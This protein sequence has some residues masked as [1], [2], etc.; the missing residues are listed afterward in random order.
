MKCANTLHHHIDLATDTILFTISSG[1]ADTIIGDMFFNDDYQQ[2][3]YYYD[4]GAAAAI[5][6]RVA[7]KSK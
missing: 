2:F 4:Y 7:K 5:S 6:K 1:I 3:N